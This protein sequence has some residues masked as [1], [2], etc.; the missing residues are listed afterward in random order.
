MFFDVSTAQVLA[1]QY[2]AWLCE[3]RRYVNRKR[4]ATAEGLAEEMAVRAAHAKFVSQVCQH[5]YL[6]VGV[7]F[8]Y[9]LLIDSFRFS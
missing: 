6:V 5:P 1:L 3:F 2:I 8:Y 4:G 7:H 9:A